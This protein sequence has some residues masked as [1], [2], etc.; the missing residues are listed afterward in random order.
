MRQVAIG[1]LGAVLD[2]GKGKERWDSWRP[3]VSLCQH[4]DL[5]I[6]RF[7]LLYE[8]KF[9]SIAQT[10]IEDI[11]HVSPETEIVT[12][13]V[14]FKDPWDF[15]EVFGVLH[16]F[17]KKYPF[18]IER[19]DYLIHITTGTHVAQ[20][21]EFLLIE[22]HYFPAKLI[23]TMPP[24]RKYSGTPGSYT[25][26][27]LDLS[28]YDRIAARFKVETSDDISFLKS[29]IKTKNK[30]FNVLIEKIE[31]VAM[32][33]TYPILLMGPT[34]AGKSKLARRIYELKKV[35][36]QVKG[37][38]VEVNCA[39]IKGDGAMSALFGHKKGS[40]TGAT[41]DRQ[42]LLRTADQGILF[43]D[44]IGELGL[45][46]QAMLL[47]AL[48]EKL[49]LPLGSDKEV[50]SDFQ[51]ICGTVRN[52]QLDVQ[53][54]RFRED[55]LSRINLWTFNLP[56]LQDRYEDIEPNL[57]YELDR[58]AETFGTHITFNKE[59]KTHF[60]AYAT[61]KQAL[62]TANFRDLN[63]SIAR[64]ATFAAGGRITKEIVEEE[65]SRLRG[66]WEQVHILCEDS[67]LT[68]ILS[69]N[70]ICELDR[71]DKVQLTE[72]L[73]IC[74]QSNNLSEAGRTLFDVSRLKRT[75]QNDADR[76]KKYLTRFDLTWKS[77]QEYTK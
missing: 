74:S 5:L 34:G 66:S 47:R 31:K 8:K 59:A 14:K 39:T 68:K 42:G 30:S 32:H 33:S 18:D 43:L 49:F 56:G 28:K 23:Q 53:K 54:G 11:K 38:F 60:L 20:I 13:K 58:L 62:W 3:T 10:V 21:C 72:V 25:I 75:K 19:E 35:R 50:S 63:A 76:L 36:R 64:M 46:E 70:R 29:G 69:K 41:S 61:S 44:E 12:T 77:I 15:E 67:I 24:K 4:E 65:I 17:A 73:Q 6:E 52:L 27:D 22:S 2:R 51:L 7:E 48:E 57:Q 45:D 71:F 16:D 40:F 9:D 55:L 1:L 37:D 26:I